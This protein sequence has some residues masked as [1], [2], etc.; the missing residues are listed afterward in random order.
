MLF[1]LKSPLLLSLFGLAFVMNGL[2]NAGE[3]DDPRLWLEDV[4]GAKSLGWVKKWRRRLAAAA[5]DDEDALRSR[6]RARIRP[7]SVMSTLAVERVLLSHC[8]ST[9]RMAERLGLG[10]DVCDPLQQTFTRWDGKG[11]PGG[12]KSLAITVTL[13]PVERT[14]TDAEIEA[15]SA[16]IVAQ[17]AKATGAVLRG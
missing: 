12:K 10:E 3:P 11:V 2:A 13:Q 4:T 9:A 7:P 6:S 5:P 17:V 16:K 8:L 15:V 14:L 1:A